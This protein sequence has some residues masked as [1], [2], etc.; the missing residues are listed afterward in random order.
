MDTDPSED[1]H[2]WSNSITGRLQKVVRVPELVQ[3]SMRKIERTFRKRLLSFIIP[4]KYAFLRQ[5]AEEM[6]GG[7]I[8]EN[9]KILPFCG[10]PEGLET[11][12]RQHQIDVVIPTTF[13][14]QIPFVSYL[15]DC[16]HKHFPE[17]FNNNDCILRDNYFQILI[18][19]SPA[20]IVNSRNARSDLLTFFQAEEQQII[21]LPF[22]PQ[23]NEGVL[24]ER[25]ELLS[26]YSLPEKFFFGIGAK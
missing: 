5:K 18:D 14:L 15:Y 22:T 16:Q 17:N 12:C 4:R 13:G 19:S 3:L 21:S 8:A 26:K 20:L 2:R 6:L 23:L 1:V 10:I 11:A 25:S 7:S 24:F 9:L